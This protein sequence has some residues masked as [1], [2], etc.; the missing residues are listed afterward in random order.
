METAMTAT[1]A[2]RVNNIIVTKT[3]AAFNAIMGIV[4]RYGSL[5]QK[6]IGQVNGFPVE[7]QHDTLSVRLNDG[8]WKRFHINWNKDFA[9]RKE[10]EMVAEIVLPY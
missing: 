8:I 4:N 10:A 2:N 3:G 6:F 5:N 9:G 7:M 1:T